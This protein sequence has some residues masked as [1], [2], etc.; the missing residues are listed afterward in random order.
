MDDNTYLVESIVSTERY[1]ELEEDLLDQL[2][3]AGNTKRYFVDLVADY[4]QLYVTKTML[5]MDI[6]HR[7]VRVRY[8]NGGGQHGYKKNDSVEQLL[9]VNTQMLKILEA[10][11]ISPDEDEPDEDDEL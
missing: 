7:G 4:M 5:Q 8:D 10:L 11:N 1:R 9:K 3:R 6:E 2:E